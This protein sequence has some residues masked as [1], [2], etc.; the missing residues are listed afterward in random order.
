M[1]LGCHMTDLARFLFGSIQSVS[2]RTVRL[3]PKR[4][5]EDHTVCLLQFETAATGT[6][7]VGANHRTKRQGLI[8]GRVLGEKGRIDFTVYPYGRAFNRASL[9]LD[10]GESVFVP[11][12]TVREL[13]VRKPPSRVKTYPGFFDVYHREVRAF[14]KAIRTGESPPCTLADG[15]SAIEVILAVYHEQGKATRRRNF[16]NRPRQYRSD[17]ESHPLLKR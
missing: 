4:I 2:G 17:A 1:E 5:T 6:I 11:D 16:V 15:R 8:T 7:V 13:K 12:T 10:G 3:N 9:T 14:L